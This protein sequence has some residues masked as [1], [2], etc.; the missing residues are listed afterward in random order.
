[1]EKLLY[2]SPYVI[3]SYMEEKPSLCGFVSL[4]ECHIKTNIEDSFPVSSG[5]VCLN[6]THDEE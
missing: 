2:S 6:E 5:L 1:M 3:F 4:I